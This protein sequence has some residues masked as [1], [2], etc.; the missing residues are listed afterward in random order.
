MID[1]QSRFRVGEKSRRLEKEENGNGIIIVLLR[2]SEGPPS[3]LVRLTRA[4]V[5]MRYVESQGRTIVIRMGEFPA[6]NGEPAIGES[7]PVL[8]STAYP[9]IFPD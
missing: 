1:L 4:R 5:C 8:P 9:R 7:A 6:G 2:D 3:R